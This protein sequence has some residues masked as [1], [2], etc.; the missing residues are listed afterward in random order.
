MRRY[1]SGSKPDSNG[2]KI[3]LSWKYV[4]VRE[5]ET[6]KKAGLVKIRDVEKEAGILLPRNSSFRAPDA[7]CRTP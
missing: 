6:Y 5:L 4:L 7:L 2:G 3:L 1:E